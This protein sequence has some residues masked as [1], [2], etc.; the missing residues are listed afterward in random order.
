MSTPS[1]QPRPKR[2][3]G[4]SSLLGRG[5][6]VIAV[7]AVLL[8]GGAALLAGAF[9]ARRIDFSLPGAHLVTDF[10]APV[11]PSPT[12]PSPFGAQRNDGP[13]STTRSEKIETSGDGS[14]VITNS[15]V[16]GNVEIHVAPSPSH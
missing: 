5:P 3:R 9:H 6:V 13:S 14:P 10:P 8:V 4:L 15:T 11:T 12:L 1:K 7:L 16:K 2:S